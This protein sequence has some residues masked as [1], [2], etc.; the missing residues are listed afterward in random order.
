MD[1]K[2][3]NKNKST[4]KGSIKRKALSLDMFG[5]DIKFNYDGE[6]SFR[7]VLG[8]LLSVLA[9]SVT[10]LFASVRYLDMID[11]ADTVYQ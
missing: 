8:F 7:T 9:I 5:R 6:D 1:H 4:M 10:I 2:R 11:Y 3:N